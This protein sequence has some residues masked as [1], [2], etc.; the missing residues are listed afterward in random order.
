MTTNDA[1]G[2]NLSAWLHEDAAHQVPDHLEEVLQRTVTTRQRRAWSSLERWLPMDTTFT[3]RLAP[4]P[5]YAWIVVILAL[6]VALSAVI[7]AVGSLP[8]NANPFG[9]ARNGSIV[10]AGSMATSTP[11]IPSL[12]SRHLSSGDPRSTSPPRSPTMARSS[13]SPVPSR[14]PRGHGGECGRYGRSPTD[15]P[16]AQPHSVGVVA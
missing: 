2:R 4:A 16:V 7:L 8:R 6:L 3:R 9:L 5:R 11:A 13:C 12:A 10:Y 1:F 15:R 14:A